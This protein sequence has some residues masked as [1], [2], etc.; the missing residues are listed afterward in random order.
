MKQKSLMLAILFVLL[1][2]AMPSL[3]SANDAKNYPGSMCVPWNESQPAPALSYS[4]IW[5][6]S[7]TSSLRVDCPCIKDSSSID[8][9]WV[10]AVDQ[11]Y[12][13]DITARLC[14]VYRNST[15]CSW[16]VNCSSERRTTGS[17]CNPQQLSIGTDLAG[18]TYAHYY[19][20]ITIPPVYSNNRSGICTYQVNE[21]D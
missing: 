16:T 21:Y 10:R 20:S 18:G 12:S 7:S 9:G 2:A 8:S 11:H 19:Y 6:P 15:G 1:C 17:S 5:N 4:G 14:S 3:T 13:Q